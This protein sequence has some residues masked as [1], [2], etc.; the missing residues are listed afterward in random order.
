M[1]TEKKF[2]TKTGF[3]HILPDRILLTRNGVIEDIAESS[4][5]NNIS[6]ILAFYVLISIGLIYVSF[7]SFKKQD[8]TMAIL[9]ALFAVYLIQLIVK[10][11]NN[12]ATPVIY[13]NTIKKVRVKKGI[14]G[15]SRARFEVFFI[16]ETGKIKKRLIMLPGTLTGGNTETDIAFNLMMEEKLF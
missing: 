3:C 1:E 4:S 15:I 2:R 5:G 14:S 11:L 12:S 8:L 16:N 9:F 10:S 13:R 6:L 7:D